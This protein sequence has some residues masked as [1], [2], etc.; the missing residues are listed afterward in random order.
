MC[1][2]HR[3]C[4]DMCVSVSEVLGQGVDLPRMKQAELVNTVLEV[5]KVSFKERR[6]IN[7]NVRPSRCHWAYQ[8]LYS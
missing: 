4:L 5:D 1:A 6:H 3:V 2:V 8:C 7:V